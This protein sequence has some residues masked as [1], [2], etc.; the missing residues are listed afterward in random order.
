M[1]FN[2]SSNLAGTRGVAPFPKA[3]R[4]CCRNLGGR[5]VQGQ[6]GHGPGRPG[7]VAGRVAPVEREL[8]G[9]LDLSGGQR[10]RDCGTLLGMG[11]LSRPLQMG[12]QGQL[13]RETQTFDSLGC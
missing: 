9:L 4:S 6:L 5:S 12:M 13:H 10:R 2:P 11:F 3:G 1:C 8:H 7:L